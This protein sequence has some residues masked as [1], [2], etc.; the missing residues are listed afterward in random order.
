MNRIIA[1]L[2]TAFALSSTYAIKIVSGPYIQQID[3]NSATIV[4]ATDVDGLSWVEIAP[5]DGSH[6]YAQERPKFFDAPLGKKLIGKIH[7]V[8]VKGL[9]SGKKYFYR[10]F[11]KELVGK[12]GDR[13][14]FGDIV[15]TRVY[16]ATPPHFKTLENGKESLQFTI[17]NDIHEK[18]KRLETFLSDIDSD[19]FVVFNGDMLSNI[20]SAEQLYEHCLVPATAM[21]KSSKPILYARGNHETRGSASELFMK[22]FPTDTGK[23]YFAKKIGKFYFVFLDS[24][25][26][27][28]DSDIEYSGTADFDNYR[29]EQAQWLEGIVN[30]DDFK[31]AYKRIVITHIPPAWGAWHG[32]INFRKYFS[33]VMKGKK[34]DVIFSAHLHGNYRYFEPNEDFDA[35]CIVNSN[36]EKVRVSATKDKIV[37]DFY[38]VNMK[39]VRTT[40]IE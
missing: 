11:T 10:A 7:R 39:K 36:M 15:S 35:P 30:S 1:L 32:S 22:Y 16:K 28:P 4:W 12:K 34:I 26:D 13:F 40:V 29:K 6:F 2:I 37:C 24:G 23:P 18:V 17:V 19:D 38:D 25:E 33:P 9:E 14:F 3:E 31:N 20:T 8:K 21:T 27:K 5:D